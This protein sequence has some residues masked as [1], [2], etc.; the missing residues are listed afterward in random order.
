M[1]KCYFK[2]EEIRFA[3]NNIKTILKQG[4]KLLI[5]ENIDAEHISLFINDNGRLRLIEKKNGGCR[6]ESLVADV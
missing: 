5:I 1:N 4:G 6:I 3:I 2:D